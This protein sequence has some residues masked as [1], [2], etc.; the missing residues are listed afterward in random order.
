MPPNDCAG[1]F[2]NEN[3][4]FFLNLCLGDFSKMIDESKMKFNLLERH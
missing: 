3:P 1:N 2:Q 4:I